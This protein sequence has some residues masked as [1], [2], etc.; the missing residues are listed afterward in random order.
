MYL[1]KNPEGKAV[2]FISLFAE[3]ALLAYSRPCAVCLLI[4]SA[5]ARSIRGGTLISTQSKNN[6]RGITL[7]I[8][9]IYTQ[10]REYK[11]LNTRFL[12]L[13][14][15]TTSPCPLGAGSGV[16]CLQPFCVPPLNTK[17]HTEN[18]A[19]FSLWGATLTTSRH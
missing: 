17:K 4:A 9:P 8:R 15:A 7:G 1:S 5:H 14:L 16:L 18:V 13:S 19:V 6:L 11:S 2:C 12:L 3:Q 10:V